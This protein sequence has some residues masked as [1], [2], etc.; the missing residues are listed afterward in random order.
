MFKHSAFA[1]LG[2]HLRLEETIGVA[3]F[4]LGAVEGRIGMG[5]KRLTIRSVVGIE[6]DADAG[7][8]VLLSRRFSC[9]PQRFQNGLGKPT[10][11]GGICNVRHQNG[12]LVAPKRAI[13]CRP[14]EHRGDAR[15]YGLK[16]LVAGGVAE[17]VVDLL[18][19]VE[20]ETEYGE[21]FPPVSAQFQV[22]PSVEMAAIGKRSQRIV[23]REKMDMLLGL[24]AGLRS[25]TA[26]T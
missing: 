23:M 9:R 22:E 14:P 20:V 24:L 16:H 17:Q 13:I 12:E 8:D 6:C 5:K 4:G 19:P 18:E 2:A 25:R 3:A 7:G 26:M 10:G 15:G 11:R 1:H 21:T